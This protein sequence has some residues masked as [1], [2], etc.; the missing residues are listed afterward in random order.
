MIFDFLGSLF[1]LTLSNEV[2]K[3]SRSSMERKQEAAL[4]N[5]GFDRKTQR[6]LEYE[7]VYA[8][9]QH[10]WKECCDEWKRLFGREMPFL[11]DY[12]LEPERRRKIVVGL[13]AEQNKKY[14]DAI[15][16]QRESPEYKRLC[17][18]AKSR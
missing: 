15:L 17:D 9:Y 5:S 11:T 4:K 2:E 16:S 14:F 3:R 1:G 12:R 7:W 10:T 18:K 13:L 8:P 6:E